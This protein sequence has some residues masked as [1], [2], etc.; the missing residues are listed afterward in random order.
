MNV[1]RLSIGDN[2][3]VSQNSHFTHAEDLLFWIVWVL[4]VIVTNI[5]F[6]NFIVAE[7]SASYTRV[8]E[9]VTAVIWQERSLML[10]EAERMTRKKYKKIEEYP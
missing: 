9:T 10:H 8:T 1:L 3:L 5:I 2:S 4:A 7:A 6:L